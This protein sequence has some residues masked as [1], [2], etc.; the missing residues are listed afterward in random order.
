MARTLLS[1]ARVGVVAALSCIVANFE[2]GPSARNRVAR[3]LW[4]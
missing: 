4:A 1:V 2:I 3:V